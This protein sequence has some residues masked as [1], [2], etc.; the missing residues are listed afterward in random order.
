MFAIKLIGI[1]IIIG[2]GAFCIA[3]PEAA[4]EIRHIGQLEYGRPSEEALRL[5]RAGGIMAILSAIVW[6]LFEVL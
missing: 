2:I 3:D 1:L 5:T 6:L 4:W